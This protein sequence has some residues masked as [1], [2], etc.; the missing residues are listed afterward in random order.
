MI[1]MAERPEIIESHHFEVGAR[2]RPRQ[3]FADGSEK[4]PTGLF[5]DALR[6]KFFSSRSAFLRRGL[7]ARVASVHLTLF[8]AAY[9]KNGSGFRSIRHDGGLGLRALCFLRGTVLSLIEDI[10]VPVSG[11]PRGS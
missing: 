7:I 3:L 4:E 5:F 6:E 2:K 9:M 1:V 8:V 10:R 11:L